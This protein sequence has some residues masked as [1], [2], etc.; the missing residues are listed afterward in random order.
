[1]AARISCLG[2]PF[3]GKLSDVVFIIRKFP[4]LLI[5]YSDNLKGDYIL[6]FMIELV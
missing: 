1:M 5:L 2:F 4:Q 3:S 6:S